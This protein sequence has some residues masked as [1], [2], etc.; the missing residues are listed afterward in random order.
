MQNLSLTRFLAAKILS[1]IEGAPGVVPIELIVQ[2]KSKE[3]PNDA[4]PKFFEMYAS[5]KRVGALVK[6]TYT[7]KLIA[8]WQKL[9]ADSTVKPDLSDM[10]TA[11]S[12]FMAV[13]DEDELVRWLS[14]YFFTLTHSTGQKIIQTA[15]AL[16][17][18]LL[19]NYVADRLES[20]LDKESKV[21]HE[22]IAA[23]IEARLGSGEGNSAKGP[24]MKVWS[25]GKGLNDVRFPCSTPIR[26]TYCSG[27]FRLTGSRW[28]FAIRL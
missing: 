28:N 19:K 6:E 2:A 24:D 17:S 23:Q 4:L 7:G 18:T 27:K 26:M 16:T 15:A 9:I 20:I 14:Y 5:K 10:S 22:M 13:K 21:S 8:E 11:V 3:A 25:K 12:A 1:Q